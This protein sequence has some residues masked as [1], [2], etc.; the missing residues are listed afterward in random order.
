MGGAA[1]EEPE[2]TVQDPVLVEHEQAYKAFNVLLRWCMVALGSGL[3]FL[4]LWFATTAGFLGALIAGIVVFVLG[5]YFLVRE[6]ASQPLDVLSPD[7]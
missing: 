5:Y 2:T 4:T 3:L 6:E 1:M 7:R